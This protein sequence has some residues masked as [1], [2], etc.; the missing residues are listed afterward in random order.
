M[1]AGMGARVGVG[2]GAR[3]GARMGGRMGA[4]M[5]ARAGAQDG[6]H[7]SRC[8]SHPGAPATAPSAE[9]EAKVKQ[10][11]LL[12]FLNSLHPTGQAAP[13]PGGRAVVWRS[14]SEC[15]PPTG[16]AHEVLMSSTNGNPS[17]LESCGSQKASE[18]NASLTE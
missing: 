11:L 9:R 12:C 2:M 16:E 18:F 1:G 4:G 17:V 5:G 13:G 3:M 8:S 6:G 14:R 15:R 10:I 7:G